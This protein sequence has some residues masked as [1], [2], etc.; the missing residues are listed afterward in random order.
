MVPPASHT[1]TVRR[2]VVDTPAKDDNT[3]GRA[4]TAPCCWH[5][6]CK[7]RSTSGSWYS[8][9]EVTSLCRLSSE[10]TL[11][12]TTTTGGSQRSMR[13]WIQVA[14]L[15]LRQLGF[16]ETERKPLS[17][18]YNSAVASTGWKTGCFTSTVSCHYCTRLSEQQPSCS[19][20]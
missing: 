16:G 6:H 2:D 15:F 8:W 20:C 14:D 5:V 7:P 19:I 4:Y 13:T 17:S 3:N 1:E 11:S 9:L 10:S 12:R 18:S